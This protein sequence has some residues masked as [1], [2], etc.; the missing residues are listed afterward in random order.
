MEELTFSRSNYFLIVVSITFLAIGFFLMQGGGAMSN[1]EFNPDELF[2]F[3]RI[4]LAPFFLLMGYVSI[5]YAILKRPT[6]Q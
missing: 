6:N 4:T 2:S 3:R 1:N 5:V